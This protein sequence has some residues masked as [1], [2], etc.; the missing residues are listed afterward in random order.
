MQRLNVDRLNVTKTLGFDSDLG[1]S[2][3]TCRQQPL[4]IVK[5]WLFPSQSLQLQISQASPCIW[6]P[7]VQKSWNNPVYPSPDQ[8]LITTGTSQLLLSEGEVIWLRPGCTSMMLWFASIRCYR[9]PLA[10]HKSW[11]AT[12]HAY[13]HNALVPGWSKDCSVDPSGPLAF[14]N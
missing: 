8:P 14:S 4:S 7:K 13:Q 1:G 11:F 10:A 6:Q 2:W 9:G 5:N 12:V 3:L